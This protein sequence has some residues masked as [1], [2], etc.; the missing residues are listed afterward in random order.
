MNDVNIFTGDGI[1]VN[2]DKFSDLTSENARKNMIDSLIEKK[3][4]SKKIQYRLKDWLI[5]R[6]RYWGVP[7]PIIYC[8]SC[9]EVLDENLPVKLP[10]NIENWKPTNGKSPLESV[11]DFFNVRCPK[12]GKSARRETD[13]MDTFVCSS[14]YFLRY[15]NKNQELNIFDKKITKKWLP[16][17]L[18]V[19]GVEHAILHLLYARFFTKALKKLG[20]LEFDE[21]FLKLFNQG[22]ICRKS[23]KT[24]RLE[25]MSKSK[26]NGVSPD[27]IIEKYGSDAL[28]LYE[29]FIGPPSDMAEWDDSAI[30]GVR[31]FLDKVFRLSKECKSEENKSTIA[32]KKKLHLTIKKVLHAIDNFHLNV[33]IALFMEFINFAN[34]NGVY[35]KD[36]MIFVRLIAPFAPHISEEIW[37]NFGE[38]KSIFFEKFPDFEQ[39]LANEDFIV[40]AISINGKVRAKINIKTNSKKDEVLTLALEKDNIKKIIKSKEN[41]KKIIFVE[42]RILNLIV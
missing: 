31:K 1:L 29:L 36:F 20:Y 32:T 2:S 37:E 10:D 28:R 38:N 14:W 17:D 4:G 6:Q 5:S 19:G 18:Y 26:E 25:K 11:S 39:K 13:T 12:C 8:N 21:P 34:K 15:P 22:M 33:V 30:S 3:I 27:E 9:G 41:I 23:P 24:N 35:K 7:I 42:N 16:V 40:M